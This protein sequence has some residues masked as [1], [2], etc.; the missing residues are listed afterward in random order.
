M[1]QQT[2]SLR[3]EVLQKVRLDCQISSSPGDP[4]AFRENGYQSVKA[5][6]G[7]SAALSN[8]EIAR[9]CGRDMDA[10]RA[11]LENMKTASNQSLL[12]VLPTSDL[13]TWLHARAKFMGLETRGESP[14]RKGAMCDSSA[15][16]LWHHDFRKQCLFIQRI[17]CFVADAETRP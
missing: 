1:S 8:Q 6:E 12:T 7:R 13:L 15:W 9:L 5:W 14:K 16:I 3:F 4:I 17:R 10:L 11:D 2:L